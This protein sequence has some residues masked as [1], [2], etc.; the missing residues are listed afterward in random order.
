MKNMEDKKI[1]ETLIKG[2]N[3]AEDLK[4]L[5][6]EKIQNNLDLQE[7]NK[8][9]IKTNRNTLSRFMKYGSIA[10][11]VSIILLVNTQYGQAAVGK[12]KEIFVPNKV[13][14]QQI[15]GM[16]ENSNVLLKEGTMKY[17][18]YVDEERYIMEKMDNKDKITPKIKAQNAPEVFMEIEQIKDKKPEALAAEYEK[19]LKTKYKRVDNKG[20]VKEPINSIS[21]YAISGSKWNDTVIKYYFIDNKSGGTFIVKQQYFFEASEG[22]GVRFDNM[23]KEFKII[24]K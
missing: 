5:V 10:A 2:T 24:E 16:D 4:K 3:E 18:I 9:T 14:K 13:V 20:I 23:L 1:N 19:N 17:I 7:N 15:E 21:L 12:I 8:K 6:W 11:A 22:H